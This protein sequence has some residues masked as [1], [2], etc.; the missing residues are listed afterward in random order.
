[1]STLTGRLYVL[2][3]LALAT[4][5]LGYFLSLFKT[6]DNTSLLA[7]VPSAITG[8]L[9]SD[10]SQSPASADPAV[11][12]AITRMTTEIDSLKAALEASQKENT[13]LRAHVRTLEAAFGP[14]TASLPPADQPAR[15]VPDEGAEVQADKAPSNVQVKMHPMP[16]DG[17]SEE[18]EQAP[19]PV[20]QP[21]TASK[22]LFAVELAS[23]LTADTV[24]PRWQ[25]ISKRYANLIHD[26]EPRKIHAAKDG[27]GNDTYKLIAGP[28]D[29]VAGAAIMCARLSIA[30]LNC[31]STTFT[32]TPLGSVATR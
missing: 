12:Q 9:E 2:A 27:N 31:T 15:P 32:G 10:N 8:L 7:S 23:G 13:A 22:T 19:L 11:S 1:M 25:K 21:V 28:F 24:E 16:I 20:A 14:T 4:V 5:A 18:I 30:G 3:W 6:E 26:L 29:N 17:F